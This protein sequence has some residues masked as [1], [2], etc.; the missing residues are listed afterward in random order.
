MKSLLISSL[1]VITLLVSTAGAA[2]ESACNKNVEMMNASGTQEDSSGGTRSGVIAQK[3]SVLAGLSTLLILGTMTPEE[4]ELMEVTSLAEAKKQNPS[5]TKEEQIKM[6]GQMLEAAALP[7]KHAFSAMHF[8]INSESQG[9]SGYSSQ[10]ESLSSVLSAEKMAPFLAQESTASEKTFDKSQCA[11][12]KKTL[13]IRISAEIWTEKAGVLITGID[14]NGAPMADFKQQTLDASN[15][16]QDVCFA[17]AQDVQT[18]TVHGYST[19]DNGSRGNVSVE[20][21]G[22]SAV[23]INK[24]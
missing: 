19:N 4:R 11:V 18:V 20:L 16:V 23:V 21:M 14:I 12:K 10:S 8:C 5:A 6:S 24:P 3:E 9:I 1:A 2:I 13:G 22:E 7:L 15:A 17:Q